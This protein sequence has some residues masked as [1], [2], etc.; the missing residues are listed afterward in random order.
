[1]SRRIKSR[2]QKRRIVEAW[3]SISDSEYYRLV[4]EDEPERGFPWNVRKTTEVEG[5]G[6]LENWVIINPKAEID[7]P[8]SPGLGLLSSWFHF[9]LAE[10]IST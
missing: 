6:N 3:D 5:H 7:Q 10:R 9:P 8:S 1:M 4:E 2:S